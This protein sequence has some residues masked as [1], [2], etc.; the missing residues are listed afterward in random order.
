MN[1]SGDHARARAQASRTPVFLRTNPHR[2]GCDCQARSRL[3]FRPETCYSVVMPLS[4]SPVPTVC[5]QVSSGSFV[6]HGP[7]ATALAPVLRICTPAVCLSTSAHPDLI[8]H[9]GK[10]SITSPPTITNKLA[11]R[12]WYGRTVYITSGTF[13]R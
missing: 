7:S 11:S 9:R 2:S 8:L 4:P 13:A 12:T 10:R 3:S 1:D 5:L 6:Q